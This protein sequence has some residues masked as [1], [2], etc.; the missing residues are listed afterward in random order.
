MNRLSLYCMHM[1]SVLSDDAGASTKH[2]SLVDAFAAAYQ[3][4]SAAYR[5]LPS[6]QIHISIRKHH[7]K[8]H[9][10]NLRPLQITN[11]NKLFGNKSHPT[12]SNNSDI[13]L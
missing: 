1:L 13:S 5:D 7:T 11:V 8:L 2:S 6:P 10:P 12:K 3:P 4:S 9:H